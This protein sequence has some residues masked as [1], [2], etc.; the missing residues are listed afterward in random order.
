MKGASPTDHRCCCDP[1][2]TGCC[3]LTLEG[4]ISQFWRGETSHINTYRVSWDRLKK[5]VEKVMELCSNASQADHERFVSM[6]PRSEN[7]HHLKF[8]LAEM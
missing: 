5:R 4:H 8:A 3:R 1:G 7:L 6:D 2:T